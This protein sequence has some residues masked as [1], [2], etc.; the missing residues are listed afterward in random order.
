ME[1]FSAYEILARKRRGEPLGES[2]IRSFID[3]FT[4]EKIADYQMAAFLMAVAIRGMTPEETAV[5]TSAMLQSGEQ[6]QLR[7]R[8]DFI[9]DKHSTG[10]VGDKI[11]LVLA[12]L[13][14]SCGVKMAMLSGRGLGHTG[15]TLDKL[16]T[17]PGFRARLSRAEVERC[18]EQAGCVIATSTDEIAPADRR[19]YE[20]RDVTATVESIPLIT[21]SIMSKKLALG[22]SALL[23]DVKTGGGAFMPSTDDAR[24][25]ARSLAAAAEGT[26]TKVEWMLT[27]MSQPLGRACGN[28][29]EVQEALAVLAGGGPEDVRELS[30]AQ[31][32]R[33]LAMAGVE[34]PRKTALKSLQSGEA[35]RAAERWLAAQ[36]ATGGVQKS[37][38]KKV[39]EVR[40]TGEGYI[41]SIDA[42]A[43]GMLLID[44]GAGRTKKTDP[45]DPVAGIVFERKRGDDVR[46]GDLIAVIQLGERQPPD[47]AE[48]LTALIEIGD[49][50]PAPRALV[51]GWS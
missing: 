29:N 20:L 22:P 24:E 17:I 30:L 45:V 50:P 42:R 38:P 21:A 4:K 7:D 14:A 16:E 47:A 15:G 39:V 26:G 28:A 33:I 48:R 12:P 36:G 6:W 10:G 27:D 11:S 5:L 31:A 19:M 49:T 1:S 40:A 44:L 37:E 34:T 18:I 43:V 8:F 13:V 23:L 46:N 9:A 41:T 25:L 32:T 35:L 51:G 2:E 3:G